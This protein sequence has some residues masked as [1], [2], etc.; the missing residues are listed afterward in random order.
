[1]FPRVNNSH[2]THS[3]ILFLLPYRAPGPVG[4][5][6]NSPRVDCWQGCRPR[7]YYPIFECMFRPVKRKIDQ[8]SPLRHLTPK[9]TINIFRE[10]F[11]WVRRT[12]RRRIFASIAIT[13]TLVNRRVKISNY[14][15]SSTYNCIYLY[16]NNQAL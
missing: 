15:S 7:L 5:F 2:S 16:R 14:Y 10:T 9:L 11:K 12:H 1:M 3:L 4:I 13:Q 8:I 6:C